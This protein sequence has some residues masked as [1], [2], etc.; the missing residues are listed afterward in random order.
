MIRLAA[1]LLATILLTAEIAAAGRYNQMLSIGDKAPAW[2]DLPGV[3]G[4][5]HSLSDLKDKEAVVV[6]FTCNSCP[7]AVDYEDRLIE[8]ARKHAGADGKVGLVAINVNKVPEDR[9]PK[10]RERA[11][12]KEFPFPY[13]YDETQK[14]AREYGAIFTPEFYVLDKERK[15]VY[16]GAM[17]DSSNPEKVTKSYLE[18]AV[19]AALKGELP[20]TKETG[21]VGCRIRYERERRRR[22]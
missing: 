18:P 21:A 11:E 5:M 2:N 19:Q 13:L 4:E 12:Q 22:E 6:V 15:V 9:P 16:M 8:F 14:I 17:D 20:E 3:D 7:Y 1:A 10:M